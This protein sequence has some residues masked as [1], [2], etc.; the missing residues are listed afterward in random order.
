MKTTHKL[1]A[2][3]VALLLLSSGFAAGYVVARRADPPGKNHPFGK[4]PRTKHEIERRIERLTEKLSLSQ[5]QQQKIRAILEDA[6]TRAFPEEE[7]RMEKARAIMEEA[8]Q[9]ID[10]VLTEEQR[11]Q[12]EKARSGDWKTPPPWAPGTTRE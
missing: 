1:I 3:F 11:A 5:E 7:A 2:A 4:P 8:R 6:V 9:K 12:M 10:A